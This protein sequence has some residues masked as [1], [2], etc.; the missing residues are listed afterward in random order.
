[1][2]SGAIAIAHGKF[3]AEFMRREEKGEKVDDGE[4]IEKFYELMWMQMVSARQTYSWIKRKWLDIIHP[5][6]S[7][8][9]LIHILDYRIVLGAIKAASDSSTEDEANPKQKPGA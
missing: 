6:P 4:M 5:I 8:E 1:M 2:M 9:R 7:K 3:M